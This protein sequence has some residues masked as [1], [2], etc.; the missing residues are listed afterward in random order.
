[1]TI[2]TPPAMRAGMEKHSVFP[3]PVGRTMRQLHPERIA[4][5]A[6]SCFP[7]KVSYLNTVCST[8]SFLVAGSEVVT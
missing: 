5:I 6:S 7:L 3:A 1:M 8:Q 2:V 4:S